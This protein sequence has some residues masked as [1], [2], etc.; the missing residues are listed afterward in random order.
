MFKT[1]RGKIFSSIIM[2]VAIAFILIYALQN[3]LIVG[4]FI[5]SRHNTTIQHMVK[6]MNYIEETESLNLSDELKDEISNDKKYKRLYIQLY[7]DKWEPQL[8]WF[9]PQLLSPYY[10]EMDGLFYRL[11]VDK[12]TNMIYK[13]ELLVSSLNKNYI[14]IKI[15]SNAINDMKF[16]DIWQ[17]DGTELIYII[18]NG[19]NSITLK[20]MY[21]SEDNF[22]IPS[23]HTSDI[24]EDKGVL[25]SQQYQNTIDVGY[26]YI[27]K[28]MN[29]QSQSYLVNNED[30]PQNQ[31][32][33]IE[34][35]DSYT[36]IPYGVDIKPLQ[37]NNNNYYLVYVSF[38]DDAKYLT[39][40][41][42]DDLIITFIA[43][44]ISAAIAY[45]Y[46]GEITAPILEIRGVTSALS[47]LDFSAKCTINTHDEI[48]G[49]AEDIN[50]M[51]HELEL[52]TNQLNEEIIKM[53][54]LEEYRKDFIAI[55][56][57]EFR[58]PLTIMR[59]ILEGLEDKVYDINDK[60]PLNI[61]KFE[62]EE[63]ETIV[64]ELLTITKSEANIMEYHPTHFQL[65]DIVQLNLNRYKYILID[66][67]INIVK[68]LED[69]FIIGDEDKISLVVK[70]V[71]SNAIKYSRKNATIN[72][73]IIR[74][75]K[76]IS[77]YIEN[78]GG[79]I[80]ESLKDE[81]WEPFKR[82]SKNKD[83]IPGFGIGLYTTKLILTAHD[84]DFSL[85]NTDRGVC[86][87][88][89]FELL[90]PDE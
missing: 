58:T 72:I 26:G 7:N 38:N 89:S 36:G 28:F 55:S 71:I 18:P 61:M 65:V 78:E 76:K 59:G 85:Y 47:K 83:K 17:F 68:N 3:I 56:S 40:F 51:A 50:L 39:P 48:E 54:K 29:E 15:Q 52:K 84:S 14:R 24:I 6:A 41:D 19:G 23:N 11:L 60:G 27:R 53:K 42:N 62:V 16:E 12:Y 46:S 5:N 37:V 57:H 73:S 90:D 2:I 10:V 66:R 75:S 31:I 43:L 33:S 79:K 77:L 87:K 69:G 67:G 25:I 9:N 80:D 81:L 49:L 45:L 64:H 4:L 20:S 1:I 34:T 30:F 63:L 22:D 70:N 21:K 82:T 13:K 35:K 32:T 86:F 88:A 8:T 44:L 74:E